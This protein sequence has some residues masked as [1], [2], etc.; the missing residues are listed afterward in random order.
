MAVRIDDPHDSWG[1]ASVRI[2]FAIWLTLRA[3][4]SRLQF[5]LFRFIERIFFSPFLLWRFLRHSNSKK[6]MTHKRS[7]SRHRISAFVV[8]FVWFQ[9]NAFGALCVCA[10]FAIREN[11][12]CHSCCQSIWN[13]NDDDVTC[14]SERNSMWSAIKQRRV[15]QGKCRR[16]KKNYVLH[17]TCQRL[18]AESLFI[19]AFSIF[20]RS[21]LDGIDE[22]STS[23]GAWA[24]INL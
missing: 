16:R 5:C 18:S 11:C 19:F 4:L 24:R 7:E 2:D 20:R 1:P 10:T 13:A 14:R 22:N 3:H 17:V 23:L 12:T 21:S 6:I 8:R 15:A 9:P